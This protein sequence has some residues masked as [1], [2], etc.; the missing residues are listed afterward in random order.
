M[1][2]NWH[3]NFRPTIVGGTV[4]Q[5]IDQYMVLFHHCS[6]GG[7]TAM[8][9][10]LHARLCRAFPVFS[11]RCRLIYISCLCYDASVVCL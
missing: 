6:I 8:P 11:A 10:E 3:T 9:G 4:K 2:I 7:N 1:L 5:C